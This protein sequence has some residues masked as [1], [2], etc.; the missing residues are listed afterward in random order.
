MSA[1]ANS[2]RAY[3]T[4][5]H[6]LWMARQPRERQFLTVLAVVVGCAVLAQSLWSAHSARA[7]LHRQLPQ[8]RQQA[9]VLQRQ[10]G[11]VRQLLGQPASPAAQEGHVLLAAATLAAR[12]S[13]LTL[14]P[15]QLQLE[16]A[17]QLRLRANVPFDRWLEW[18]A[19]LQKD[20]R[21]RLINCRV[22]AADGAIGG[23]PPGVIRVDA[24]FAL[25]EPT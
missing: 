2:F 7:R 16:G 23:Y 6:S 12:N 22:D 24:L 5:F 19:T 25:P 17:R 9:E 4:K 14:A 1:W 18:V 11:E 15:T 20:G 10:A 3:F 8:L 13:G 21:L